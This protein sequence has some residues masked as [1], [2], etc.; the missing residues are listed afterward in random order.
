MK[1]SNMID[2]LVVDTHKAALMMDGE[3][4]AKCE[5]KG[6]AYEMAQKVNSHDKLTEQNKLLR[7]ALAN[8]DDVLSGYSK[9]PSAVKLAI[10]KARK[11]LGR[12]C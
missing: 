7:E 12:T 1:M 2:V 3:V 9:P 11:A 5:T 10:Y 6:I 8:V 4:V